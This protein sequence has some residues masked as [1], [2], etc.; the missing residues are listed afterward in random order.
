MHHHSE[1]NILATAIIF[2]SVSFGFSLIIVSF[3]ASIN[4]TGHNEIIVDGVCTS[5]IGVPC[6]V[7]MT[8]RLYKTGRDLYGSVGVS[9]FVVALE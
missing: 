7:S 3:E 2:I 8:Q 6:I 5:T 4:K 1:N 9:N